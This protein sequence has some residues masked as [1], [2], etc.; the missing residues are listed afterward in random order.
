MKR[1]IIQTIFLL[2]LLFAGGGL[3]G[4]EKQLCDD[5]VGE[6]SSFLPLG[7]VCRLM[8]VSEVWKNAIN[9]RYGRFCIKKISTDYE[10]KAFIEL[11]SLS[12][13]K[14]KLVALNFYKSSINDGQLSKIVKALGA[15]II[16]LN[17]GLCDKITDAGLKHLAGLTNLKYLNLCSCYKITDTFNIYFF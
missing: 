13:L 17:L 6:V 7:D 11:K 12:E 3:F 8:R 9:G 16:Y 1:N 10:L 2:G 14:G 4:M 5:C 15:K